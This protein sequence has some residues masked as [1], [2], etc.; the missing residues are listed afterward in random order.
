MASPIGK[1]KPSFITITRITNLFIAFIKFKI[2][3]PNQPMFSFQHLFKIESL[4]YA[5]HYLTGL[6]GIPINPTLQLGKLYEVF[7]L[8]WHEYANLPLE[9]LYD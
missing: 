8:I 1:A 7:D 4:I 3:I 2:I 5:F 6:I 9:S